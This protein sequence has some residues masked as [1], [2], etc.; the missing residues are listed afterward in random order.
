MQEGDHLYGV[1]R[2][3]MPPGYQ[4]VQ[5]SHA[6]L[7]FAIECPEKFQEWYT[8]SE[9]LCVLAVP[10]E[11]GLTRILQRAKMSGIRCCA[12]REP[13]VGYRITAIALEPGEKTRK[14]LKGLP[15]ALK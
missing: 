14:L 11:E 4:S 1:V 6:L 13:D 10:D 9:Y 5:S 3:D 15:L 12:F 2:A 7:K 8:R